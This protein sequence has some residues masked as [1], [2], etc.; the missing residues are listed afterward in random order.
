MQG[1]HRGTADALAMQALKQEMS[2]LLAAF[3]DAR[4]FHDSTL[5]VGNRV[6][7]DEAYRRFRGRDADADAPMRA[8]GFLPPR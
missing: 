3:E 8:R 6:P 2:P 4:R 5:S 7:P 1:V